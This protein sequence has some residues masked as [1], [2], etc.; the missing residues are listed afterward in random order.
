MV[1]PVA[2]LLNG[3]GYRTIR[4][5]PAGLA[6]EPDDVLVQ[7]S[8]A[9]DLVMVTFDTDLRS[10]TR[11]RGGR[12]LH[13]RPPELTAV[14]RLREHFNAVINLLQAGNP[15]VTLPSSGPPFAG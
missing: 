1:E 3:R 9:N 11:R 15:L 8:L 6:I 2:M 7:Y 4:A 13:I 5:R 12:C 14:E 10:A